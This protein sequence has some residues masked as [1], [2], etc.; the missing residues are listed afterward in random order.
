MRP[1]AI[2]RDAAEERQM[3]ILII[4]AGA[5]GGYF[6]GRLLEAGRDVTFLVRPRRAEQLARTGIVIQSRLGDLAL[7]AP[8]VTAEALRGPFDLIL[9]SCK[10]YDL[11][12]AI[13]A[14]APAVGPNSAIL[15]VLNGMRHLEMLA[16]RFGAGAVLG[17]YCIISSDLD[18]AGRVVHLNESHMIGFG[19]QDGAAS[20]RI[21]A[22]TSAFAGARLDARA[23]ATI[24]HEMWEKWV[25]IGAAAGINC[26]LRAAVGDIVAAGAADL[27]VALLDEC[28]AVAAG[29]GF[30]PS[31]AALQRIR[32]ML[33]AAGSPITAS[34]LRDIER[35]APTEGDHILGDLLRRGGSAAKPQ[36]LLRA[37]A[38]HR[39]ASAARRARMQ[40]APAAG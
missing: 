10:A 13:A 35:N 39:A 36:G 26:L 34:M 8:T 1:H 38:A 22:I 40:A 18:E 32:A 19:E 3:R 15:P 25:F 28:A 2:G 7:P 23:S 24:L 4:G 33:T 16:E 9:L 14:F 17:G 5:I 37:A 20:A 27:A 6:G 11:P 12:G 30:P 21:G 29:Q 31:D